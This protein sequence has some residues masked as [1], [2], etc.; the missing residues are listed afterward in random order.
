MRFADFY[1]G[2]GG[3]TL[4]LTLAGHTQV[5]SAEIWA[6]A[7][8]T[9]AWNFGGTE[10]RVDVR[11]IDPESVPDCDLLVGSP[12]CTQFSYANKGGNGD[13]ADGLQDVRAFLRIVAA[14]KPRYWVMENVPRLTGILAAELSP[15]GALEEFAGLFESVD[16]F[17]MSDWG[18]PQRRRRCVA[19]RYPRDFLIS[20]RGR[21]APTL[22][23]VV[24]A[25]AAGKDPVWGH[26]CQAVTDN[27]PGLSLTWE[28][29]RTNSEKKRNHPIYNDMAFPD[30]PDRTARTV[31][32]TCTKVS[33]ESIVVPDDQGGFRLLSVRESAT[34][35]SFPLSYQFAS[36]GKSDRIKMAGNAIPPFFTYLVGLAADGRRLTDTFP[37]FS[38][39]AGQAPDA[40]SEN[41]VRRPARG[42]RSFRAAI[43]ELR[44]KSGMSFELR[45]SGGA[46]E[47][48][49]NA[50]GPGRSLVAGQAEIAAAARTVP[51]RI[52]PVDV[53]GRA[54]FMQ[55]AWE[56]SRDCD[57][58][59]YR[60]AEKIGSAAAHAVD[61]ARAR[62]CVEV[63]Y[64][65]IGLPVPAKAMGL[66]PRIA[67]GVA[68]AHSFNVEAARNEAAE[69][70]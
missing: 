51:S 36:S 70:A 69:A 53:S 29:T 3:W 63:L 57:I 60:V 19:G 49:F 18:V 14:K 28:E 67:A 7:N 42:G 56:K 47:I 6:T 10:E 58:H 12:P 31:T 46:W 66:A 41:P 34:V 13:I 50:G 4:G 61:A 54:S 35:Q 2:A 45:N 64:A 30:A 44:F 8:R 1:A 65:A 24:A 20:L 26:D 21:R 59:P 27:D 52:C 33:R 55:E 23:E 37:A 9:R 62:E 25:V 22:S 40:A 68:L 16:D 48:V 32:A 43:S 11:A 15:G 17:D 38:P 5:M 39:A